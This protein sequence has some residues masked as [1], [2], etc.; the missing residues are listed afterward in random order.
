MLTCSAKK[1]A[2]VGV[3]KVNLYLVCLECCSQLCVLLIVWFY[4]Q[5]ACELWEAENGSGSL[6]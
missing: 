3:L 1:T 4:M 2:C 5:Y 6:D